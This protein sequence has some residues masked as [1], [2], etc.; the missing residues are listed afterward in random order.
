[1]GLAYQKKTFV[2]EI[3]TVI[4]ERDI[5]SPKAPSKATYLKDFHTAVTNFLETFL[6]SAVHRMTAAI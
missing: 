4:I 6:K 2:I 1:M 5:D 3:P